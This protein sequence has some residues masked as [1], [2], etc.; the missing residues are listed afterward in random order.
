MVQT[1]VVSGVRC[2]RCVVFVV[3]ICA[4]L[5]LRPSKCFLRESKGR[6]SF[7]IRV[8]FA[9]VERCEGRAVCDADG[10]TCCLPDHGIPW[11]DL[12]RR[13]LLLLLQ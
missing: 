8:A 6:L 12:V 2:K 10:L 5:C 13:A 3:D 7:G 1:S 4:I 9:T 11:F